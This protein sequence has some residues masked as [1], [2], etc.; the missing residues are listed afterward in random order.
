MV[1]SW[2]MTNTFK[3]VW[4]SLDEIFL[5]IEVY[6][7]SVL[8]YFLV[9]CSGFFCGFFF[10]QKLIAQ[11]SSTIPSLQHDVSPKISGPGVSAT[12]HQVCS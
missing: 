6:V 2:E 3:S 12:Y 1:G 10:S 5:R 11:L 8:F 7:G 9:L 4:I